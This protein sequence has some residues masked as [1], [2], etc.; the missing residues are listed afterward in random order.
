MELPV[1]EARKDRCEDL[2]RE[3][4]EISGKHAFLLLQD[5]HRQVAKAKFQDHDIYGYET[6]TAGSDY[7]R[8]Q[9][10]CYK[11]LVMVPKA[12]TSGIMEREL[13]ERF[14]AVL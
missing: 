3:I 4:R 12:L 5:V 6:E 13:H 2:R 14:T 8:V 1:R 9:D 7:K 11:T 10:H